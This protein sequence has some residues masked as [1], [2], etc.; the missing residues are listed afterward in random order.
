MI[1]LEFRMAFLVRFIIPGRVCTIQEI[2]FGGRRIVCSVA[3]TER[4]S[5]R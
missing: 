2:G 5:S 4:G 1:T 3:Q